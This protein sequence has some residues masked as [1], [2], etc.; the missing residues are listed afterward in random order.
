MHALTDWT[1]LV[2]LDAYVAA[3]GTAAGGTG[4]P[5]Q[6]LAA[7]QLSCLEPDVVVIPPRQQLITHLAPPAG[8]VMNRQ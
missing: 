5:G 1:G 4:R 7:Q 2:V 8:S 6:V 3:A